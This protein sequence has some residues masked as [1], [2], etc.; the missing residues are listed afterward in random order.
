[1]LLA[2]IAVLGTLGAAHSQPLRRPVDVLAVVLLVAGPLSLALLRRG[3]R[4]VTW[5]VAGTTLAYLVAGYPYGPVFIS[6]VVVVVAAVATGHRTT[7]W[8][9]TV[10]VLAGHFTL[11]GLLHDEPWSWSQVLGVTAWAVVALVVAEVARTRRERAATW[12]RA[13][14]ETERRQAGEERLRIAQ[15]V[16]DVVAHHMSLINVQASVALHLAAKGSQ[17]VEPALEA[18]KAASKEA[19][20]EM[21]ELVGVLRDDRDPAPRSPTASLDG[22]DELVERSRHAGLLVRRH[23]EGQIRPVPATVELAAFR[24]AQEAI[25]NVVRHSGARHADIR[26]SYTD[27]EL[28]VQVDDDGA[29]LLQPLEALQG[30]GLRGMRERARALGGTLDVGPA[31]LGGVSVRACLPLRATS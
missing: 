31:V 13:R 7:A 21:R 27:E 28:V 29:G 17:P 11:R 22:L 25:T 4:L 8:L 1:V 26:L 10:V 16:H 14:A 9:V 12:R 23:D 18:I 24:I 5:F 20:T 30:N 6:L 3:P 2:A 19:L 15:E